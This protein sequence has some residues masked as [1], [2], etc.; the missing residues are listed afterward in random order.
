MVGTPVG[1]WVISGEN[2][3]GWLTNHSNEIAKAFQIQFKK[4]KNNL[5]T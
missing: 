4:E 5:I 2:V 3:P 1:N